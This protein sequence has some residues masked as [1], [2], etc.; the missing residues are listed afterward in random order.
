MSLTMFGYPARVVIDLPGGPHDVSDCV[1]IV[2]TPEANKPRT[3]FW[4]DSGQLLTEI[5]VEKRT[6]ERVS[7]ERRTAAPEGTAVE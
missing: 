6:R 2:S 4:I 5:E 7:P 3:G 1:E